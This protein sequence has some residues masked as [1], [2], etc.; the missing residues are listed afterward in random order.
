MSGKRIPVRDLCLVGIFAA[1]ISVL[2]PLGFPMPYGVPMTLQTFI[3]PFSGVALGA[4]RGAASTLIYVLL[5]IS[6]LPVFS[7]F[8]G[9][10]GVLFGRTGG[11]I[12]SFP[13]MALT[14]GIGAGKNKMTWLAAGLVTGSAINFACGM[15][16][17]GF[18]AH[19]DIGSAFTACVLPFIPAA[20]IK[21]LV[22]AALGLGF[23]KSRLRL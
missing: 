1:I 5:G 8:T 17:F 18:I 7:G 19:C 21:I 16:M 2:S 12:V 15:L 23:N 4:K 22:I 10:L 20:L 3:I 14:A 9:G 13:I 6:G 11:F